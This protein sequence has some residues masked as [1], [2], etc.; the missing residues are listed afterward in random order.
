MAD[1]QQAQFID[2]GAG[3]QSELSGMTSDVLKNTTGTAILITV[4]K[5]DMFRISVTNLGLREKIALSVRSWGGVRQHLAV[6][7]FMNDLNR[8]WMVQEVDRSV[9]NDPPC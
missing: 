9:T 6:A 4:E 3:A 7:R 8:F 1:Q 2:R 5:P